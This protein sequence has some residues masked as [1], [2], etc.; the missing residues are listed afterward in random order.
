MLLSS[1]DAVHSGRCGCT[2]THEHVELAD[3][4]GRGERAVAGHVRVALDPQKAQR[5]K[6]QTK[7]MHYAFDFRASLRK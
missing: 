7:E 6:G 1:A 5:R 4:A 3:D 2:S